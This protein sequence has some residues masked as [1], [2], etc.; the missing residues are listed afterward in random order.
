[1]T[2]MLSPPRKQSAK[3]IVGLHG[4]TPDSNRGID[5]LIDNREMFRKR[6]QTLHE[7]KSQRPD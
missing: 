5:R 7:W 6:L 4:Q 1:M 3:L 2:K